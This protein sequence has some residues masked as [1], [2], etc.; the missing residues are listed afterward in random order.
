M[1][2]DTES[3]AR[4]LVADGKGILAADETPGTLTKRFDAL[5]IH[6]TEQSRRAYR[7]M[8]FTAPDAA[9][10]ISGVIMQDETIR[11]KSSTGTPFAQM[12]A[13]RGIAPGI[14]V[15]T[16]AK[17]L[18]LAPGETITEGVDGLRDRLAE[19][20]EMGARFAK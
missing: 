13:S 8:L 20:R 2:L 5:G 15:D 6:S 14:K 19:Y 11:Q 16:G 7:Q 3:T 12:L 17:P 9:A 10:Y 18:A 1:N 4:T